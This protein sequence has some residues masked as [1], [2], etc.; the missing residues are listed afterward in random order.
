VG[1]YSV[2]VTCFTLAALTQSAL[3]RGARPYPTPGVFVAG[4]LSALGFFFQ[5]RVADEFKDHDDDA[6]Y[7]PY[8]PVPRGLIS[9]K[10]LAWLALLAG[11]MQALLALWVGPGMLG[12]LLAVWGFLG[13]MTREFFVPYFL[14]ARP[15]AYMLSHMLIVPLIGLY[16]AGFDWLDVGHAPAAGL[17][18]FLA[19]DFTNGMVLEVGRKVRA[20]ADEEEGVETYSRLWGHDLARR[21]WLALVAAAG[22]WGTAAAWQSGF[23]LAGALVYPGLLAVAAAAAWRFGR[24]PAHGAGR[25]I[26]QVAGLWVAGSYL[27][28]ILGPLL[29]PRG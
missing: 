2:L 19:L 23:G 16:V 17:A 5:M 9:L 12:L 8:R 24:H 28:L 25:Q 13:L 27:L 18:L 7:R 20:P 22:V 11:A 4:A 10:T 14:R 3:A 21:R 1:Q 26:E 15:M 6:R 29:L